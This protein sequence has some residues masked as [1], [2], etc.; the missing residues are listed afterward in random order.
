MMF[1]G[2]LGLGTTERLDAA[3]RASHP[4]ID[5]EGTVLRDSFGFEQPTAIDQDEA[6][7]ADTESEPV[8]VA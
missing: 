6:G 3:P 2:C 7:G 1:A 4:L 5:E 8:C